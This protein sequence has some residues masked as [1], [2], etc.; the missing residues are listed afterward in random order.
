MFQGSSLVYVSIFH[1]CFMTEQYSIIW[2]Y[3][4]LFI[5]LSVDRHMG[6]SYFLDIVCNAAMKFFFYKFCGS[7]CVQFPWVSN[8]GWNC[9]VIGKLCLTSWGGSSIVWKSLETTKIAVEK[10]KA[11]LK[12]DS[13]HCDLF[14]FV[15]SFVSFQKLENHPPF[16]QDWNFI[17]LLCLDIGLFSSTDLSIHWAFFLLWN[18]GP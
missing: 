18:S 13:V 4:I 3:Q 6:C 16:L 12:P 15:C 17:M 8:R 9:W 7:I 5:H 11:F 14:F 1:S 10:S 2:V